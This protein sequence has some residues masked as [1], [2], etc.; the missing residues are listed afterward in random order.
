[1]TRVIPERMRAVQIQAYD[2]LPESLAVA[3]VPVPRPGVGEVLV[4]IHTAPINPSDLAFIRGRYGFKKALP[5]IPGFEGSGTVVA[6]GPGVLPW[7]MRD[8]RVACAL[9]EPR[10]ASGTWAEYAVAPA[11][12]CAPLRRSVDLEQA[13]MMFVN[14]LM[15]WV[16]VHEARR[17]RH[18]AVVQNAAASALGKMVARLARRFSVPVLNIVRRP[19]Q[20]ADLRALGADRVLDSTETSFDR[21][22]RTLCRELGATIAFDAVTGEISGRMLLAMPTGSRLIVYGSLS[23][24]AVQLDPRSLIFEEK[25]VCGLWLSRWMGKRNF[26]AQLSVIERVQSLLST[27]LKS[28]IQARFRLEDVSQALEQYT[29]NMSAG[30]VLLVCHPEQ[31]Q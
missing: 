12:R 13:A 1:M 6:I 22:L 2:G 9:A 17:G 18:K 20:A 4:R 3:E 5:A 21:D 31:C 29:S 15:A 14:P 8:R 28:D 11:H 23:E 10:H 27:D 19:Q 7:I 16:L 26:L 25:A 30:K 24:S